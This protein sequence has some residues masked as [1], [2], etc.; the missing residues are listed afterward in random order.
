M[1]K[2][3][4]KVVSLLKN[5]NALLLLTNKLFHNTWDLYQC[6]SKL[7]GPNLDKGWGKFFLLEY[8]ILYNCCMCVVDSAGMILGL[9]L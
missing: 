3:F 9:E 5:S 8:S 7:L 1:F 2:G 6:Q 4:Q